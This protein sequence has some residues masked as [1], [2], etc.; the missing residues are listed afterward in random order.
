MSSKTD[1]K[2][3]EQRRHFRIHFPVSERPIIEIKGKKY[4]VVDA[5]EQGL[6]LSVEPD[7]ALNGNTGVIK[8]AITFKDK[9]TVNVVGKVL[10]TFQGNLILSLSVGLPLTTIMKQQR[11][12]L[13]KYGQLGK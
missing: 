7:D 10:R 9:E 13:Q 12:L 6:A 3:N 1:A 11:Y 8:G 5:S 2:E 4:I